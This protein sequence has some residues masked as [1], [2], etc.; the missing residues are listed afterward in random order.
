MQDSL[1][2]EL[3]LEERRARG[4][5]RNSP[6]D[7]G[8]IGE[9]CSDSAQALADFE[10]QSNRRPQRTGVSPSQKSDRRTETSRNSLWAKPLK[11]QFTCPPNSHSETP[12]RCIRGPARPGP[13]RGVSPL[14]RCTGTGLTSFE[15]AP[16]EAARSTTTSSPLRIRQSLKRQSCA[17]CA[18]CAIGEIS[19]VLTSALSL[20]LTSA[21]A[22]I[23]VV[24]PSLAE[25]AAWPVVKP[26][27]METQ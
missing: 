19:R 20:E 14:L 24:T 5:R 13:R 8:L 7:E 15:G 11:S 10:A 21:H 12:G 9:T 4:G 18:V 1:H 27:P 6:Q 25:T 3:W 2:T 17:R 26:V 23:S 16:T 22:C